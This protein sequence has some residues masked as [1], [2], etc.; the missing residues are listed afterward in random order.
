MRWSLPTV[1]CPLCSC[2][3]P[4]VWDVARVAV[5]IDLDQ[6]IV[7]AV[8]VS[9]HAC[10]RAVALSGHSRRFFGLAEYTHDASSRKGSAILLCQ[11][12]IKQPEGRHLEWGSSKLATAARRSEPAA[13]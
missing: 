5:D 11:V 6:P 8:Q 10:Q 2:A 3:R 12:L 13:V 9:V 4:R 1:N 7:L